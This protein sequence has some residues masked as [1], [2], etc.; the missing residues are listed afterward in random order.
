MIL[1]KIQVKI[2]LPSAKTVLLTIVV[3]VY[4]MTL[5]TLAATLLTRNHNLHLPSFGTI[6][7]I[8]YEIY[9]GDIIIKDGYPALD[10]G[11]TNV[12]NSTNRSFYLRSTSNI[13]TIPKLNITDW[14]FT[15]SDMPAPL[16]A[17]NKI[18]VTW[19]L[20]DTP[21]EPDQ[22][23]YVTTKLEIQIDPDFIKY[24]VD[25]RVTQFSF[26]MTIYPSKV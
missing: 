7:T 12:G 24:L 9:G 15:S 25:N 11:T 21:I 2:P 26:N 20:N 1:E 16:P 10:W 3:V 23:V 6:Y 17:A 22:E 14:S 4:T 8:G 18:N 19:N 5:T 13:P